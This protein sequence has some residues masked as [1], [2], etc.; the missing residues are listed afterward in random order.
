MSYL[1]VFALGVVAL[2]VGYYFYQKYAAAKVNA[3][4]AVVESKP[5]AT[6]SGPN[7]GVK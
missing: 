4:V 5:G 2:G 1:V 3:V 6:G 7:S